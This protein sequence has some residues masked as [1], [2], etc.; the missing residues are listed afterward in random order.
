MQL[1]RF[2][3]FADFVF[4]PMAI[5]ALVA[6]SLLQHNPLRWDQAAL[7]FACGLLLWTLAEYVIHRFA[8]HGIASIAVLH[9]MHHSDPRALVGSPLWLSLGSIFLGS[10][11][12][13]WLL[14]GL[15]TACAVTAGLMLGYTYFGL[16]HHVLHHH[17][18]RRGSYLWRLKRRHVRHH[19]G[20]RPC[21]FGVTTDVW[22][23]V[24]GTFCPE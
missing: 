17:R 12:P 19:Y 5:V 18:A 3:Y 4:Y 16:L 22:D 11:L 10:L 20:K 21:N 2:L 1:T 9:E 13:I 23:R 14:I 24:F 8:L 7:G 15:A 6:A